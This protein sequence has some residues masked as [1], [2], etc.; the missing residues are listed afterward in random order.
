MNRKKYLIAAITLLMILLSTSVAYA[1]TVSGYSQISNG[2]I[3]MTGYTVT[4]TD[5]VV[6]QVEAFSY[7]YRDG[8]LVDTG[9]DSRAGSNYAQANVSASNL[10]GNQ[11]W[12]V[13][14]IHWADL[15]GVSQTKT[16]SKI[17]SY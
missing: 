11:T 7:F 3:T 17:Q 2:V 16:S 4:T 8:V 12:E 15:D 5:T 10:P 6:D 13:D 14:G 9:S 1:Y